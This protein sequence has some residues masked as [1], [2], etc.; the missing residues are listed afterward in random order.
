MVFASVVA[1]LLCIVLIS[2]NNFRTLPYKEYYDAIM[3]TCYFLSWII[4]IFAVYR[5]IKYKGQN[6]IYLPFGIFGFIGVIIALRLVDKNA[7]KH[8]KQKE[9]L[10]KE[11]GSRPSSQPMRE[12]SFSSDPPPA[13][14]PPPPPREE[15]INA[16][17]IQVVTT[18]GKIYNI[19]TGSGD[20]DASEAPMKTDSPPPL[21]PPRMERPSSPETSYTPPPS[22]P[23]AAPKKPTF[24]SKYVDAIK[25]KLPKMPRIPLPKIPL[26]KIAGGIKFK[27]WNTWFRIPK[28]RLKPLSKQ[29]YLDEATFSLDPKSRLQKGHYVRKTREQDNLGGRESR[30]RSM[31]KQENIWGPEN[32][33][34]EE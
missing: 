3:V 26:P 27:S 29:N 13:P 17:S 23:A 11:F 28:L 32:K 14:T 1:I 2:Q 6:E 20:G 33:K 34:E 15:I 24:I 22:K 31:K 30:F 10:K 25:A 5:I 4:A 19:R 7:A 18:D 12:P 9:I 21:P 16:K 8:N